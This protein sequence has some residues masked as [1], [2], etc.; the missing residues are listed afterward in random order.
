LNLTHK[1]TKNLRAGRRL[2]DDTRAAPCLPI[3]NAMFS[4]NLH[5]F[6]ISVP[7]ALLNVAMQY[8]H[9]TGEEVIHLLKSDFKIAKTRGTKPGYPGAKDAN[10]CQESP[11]NGNYLVPGVC[12]FL[13]AIIWAV[14]GQTIK[15]EFIGFDDQAYVYENPMVIHGLSLKGVKWAFT[16][17]V[18]GNWHPLTMM[19]HMLDCQLFGLNAGGHHL[20]NILIHTATAMLLFLGLR[21]MTGCLWRSAFVAAVFAIHPLRVES[22]AWVAERKD[23][24]SGLFFML[25]LWAYLRHAQRQ[26]LGSKDR[27]LRGWRPRVL[28]FLNL[29]YCLVLLFFTLGLMCKPMLVTLPLVLLLLDF[30]PLRRCTADW[31]QI[32]GEAG[33]S[34]PRRS[35]LFLEKLPLA[36]LAIASCIITMFAQNKA[37]MPGETMPLSLRLGNATI[38]YVTYLQQMFWPSGLAVLYPLRAAD[39]VVLKVVLSLLLLGGISVC[40]FVVRGR[41]PYF[42]TGWLWY[43]IM[44][45]PAIGIVQVG[46]QARADRYTYL[47]QI[48]LYV[49]VTWVVADLCRARP[50]CRWLLGGGATI[51]LAALMICARTQTSYWQN[52]ETLWNHTL[53]CTSD[54]YEAEND[55]GYDLLQ[56]GRGDEAMAHFRRIGQF[57]PDFADAHYNLGLALFK[58]GKLDEAIAQYQTA[59]RIAPGQA[60]VCNNLGNALFQSGKL[61]EAIALYEKALAIS[62]DDATIHN[63]LGNA[64]LQDGR[65]ESAIIH[66]KK[67]LQLDSDNAEACFNLGVALYQ[68]G[69]TEEAIAGYQMALHI[70][71]GFAEAYNNLGQAFCQNGSVDKAIACCEKALQI[72]PDYQD[73]HYNLAV[74]LAR[75]GRFA[76]AVTHYKAALQINPDHPEI[77]NNLALLLAACSDVNIRDGAQAIQYA[78]H[79]CELTHYRAPVIVSTMAVAYAEAGRFDD[80]IATAQKA[81]DLASALG[82]QDL[83]Q[84]DQQLLALFRAHKPYREA[85]GNSTPAK[86]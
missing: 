2:P 3:N 31:W 12:L 70:N 64:L 54:N 22:V 62:P 46:I 78:H 18:A 36:G 68:M 1:T 17:F 51:I 21:R 8:R 38:S 34:V 19:S 56:K 47:P 6:K 58:K 74:A 72:K 16:H 60:D 85:T 81:C 20:T 25:T 39:I 73:A 80:A 24:L 84:Q 50:H 61:D 10:P 83:L 23:V 35:T 43:L 76:A 82:E 52:S 53:A 32:Q 77:L 49:L 41:W 4:A 65:L 29:D 63:N 27:M 44:L 40:A 66:F 5:R 79:A 30:W 59:L 28:Q 14:F 37:I 69:K 45:V 26:P 48:G 67:A 57:H 9:A 11:V 13:A 75:Q 15:H 7:L 55:L 42:L 71:P 33:I 86:P